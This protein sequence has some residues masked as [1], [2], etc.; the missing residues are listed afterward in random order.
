MEALDLGLAR[1]LEQE[2]RAEDVR[3]REQARI[4]DRE[5]VV[6]LGREVDDDVDLMLEQD[7]LDEVDIGDVRLDERNPLLRALEVGAVACVGQ[8]VERDDRVV[9]MPLEPVVD[10]VGADEPGRA[11]DEDPHGGIVRVTPRRPGVGPDRYRDRPSSV[12]VSSPAELLRVADLGPVALELPRALEVLERLVALAELG[13]RRAEV[14]LRV[15]L[16]RDGRCRRALRP[17]AG[18]S[19]RRPRHCR[20]AGARLPGRSGRCR[21]ESAA[22]AVAEAA[23][24]EEVRAAAAARRSC[25]RSSVWAACC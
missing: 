24:E 20:H 21:W 13:E 19:A 4:D 1:G 16:V 18:R 7:V 5:A 11:G 6:R 2:L 3:A 25:G 9:G 12:A 22:A 15:R 17:P 23:E 8:E 14:V 10:E